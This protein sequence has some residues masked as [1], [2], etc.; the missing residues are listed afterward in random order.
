MAFFIKENSSG[1][2]YTVAGVATTYKNSIETNNDSASCKYGYPNLLEAQA[3]IS[4]F[5]LTNVD[6][7]EE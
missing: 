3:A 1:S 7:V 6:I 4:S 5:G 2:W